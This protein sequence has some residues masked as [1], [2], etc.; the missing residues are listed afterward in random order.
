[1]KEPKAMPEAVKEPSAASK[2]LRSMSIVHQTQQVALALKEKNQG[3]PIHHPALNI[4]P[5]DKTPLPEKASLDV[6]PPLGAETAFKVGD[7]V[8]AQVKGYGVTYW[9]GMVMAPLSTVF[10]EADKD[11]DGKTTF[12]EW[13]QRLGHLVEADVLR[14]LFD[15]CD[16][17]KNG[18][19]DVDEFTVGLKGKYEIK[20]AQVCTAPSCCC[21]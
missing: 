16:T 11:G 14:R 21:N 3:I 17:D 20:W 19:L 12:E 4:A 7:I 13:R 5:V 6:E 18:T 15:D 8:Q 2:L 1:V 10:K 9:T